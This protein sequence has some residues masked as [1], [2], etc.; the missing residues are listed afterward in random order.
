MVG[1]ILE[2]ALPWPDLFDDSS[3]RWPEVTRIIGST[4]SSGDTEWLARVAASDA[5]H[6][7]TPWLA[8]E[9]LKIRPDRRFSHGLVLH[10]RRQLLTA[11]GFDLSNADRASISDC[12][13]ESEFE[14]IDS[15]A[16][17]EYVEGS[18]LASLGRCIHNCCHPPEMGFLVFSNM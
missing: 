7:S 17:A 4:P 11:V 14:S 18:E 6:D 10:A 16:E 13:L 8:I 15:G 5:I 1:D 9:G 12:Q 3:D 2:E